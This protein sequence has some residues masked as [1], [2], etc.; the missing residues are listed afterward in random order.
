MRIPTHPA[1]AHGPMPL[2]GMWTHDASGMRAGHTEDA[3]AGLGTI[4]D[5][6]GTIWAW[7]TVV[8]EWEVPYTIKS[9][10]TLW[11]LTKRFYG[12]FSRD[13]VHA[14][15]LV[16]QNLA[17]QGPDPDIGLIPGDVILIPGLPQPAAAPAAADAPSG[18]VPQDPVNPGAASQSLPGDGTPA[19]ADIPTGWPA[20]VPY[21]PDATAPGQISTPSEVV[22]TLPEVTIVGNVPGKKKPADEPFWTGGRIVIASVI[23]LGGLGTVVW[24]ATRKKNRGR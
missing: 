22:T 10:D 8:G 11:K 14:I 5:G 19:A 21:P 15:N 3:S 4:T 6:G 24:L 1:M 16:P 20:G 18:D 17:I 2:P 23:G 9:G 13:G 7:N 12:V